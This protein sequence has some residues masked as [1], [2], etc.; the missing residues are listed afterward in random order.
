MTI[1]RIC[2][3]I[4]RFNFQIKRRESYRK[5]D[6]ENYHEG[7]KSNCF[8]SNYFAWLKALLI[9]YFKKYLPQII[10]KL[11]SKWFYEKLEPDIE[12]FQTSLV[13]IPY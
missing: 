3:V 9:I 7:L 13:A 1:L 11:M 2:N 6:L 5:Y 8:Y 12:A 10:S 4:L